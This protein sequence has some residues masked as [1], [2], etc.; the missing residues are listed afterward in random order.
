MTASP[1]LLSR[2]TRSNLVRQGLVTAIWRQGG[3][4]LYDA[5]TGRPIARLRPTGHDDIV[6]VLWPAGPGVWRQIGDFGGIA[7]PL[8]QAL[9]YVSNNMIIQQGLISDIVSN[10]LQM[11]FAPR[12]N[13]R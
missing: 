3:C 11:I 9:D 7:K 6:E 1:P 5:V 13:T 2:V 12:K 10:L 8:D 4:T